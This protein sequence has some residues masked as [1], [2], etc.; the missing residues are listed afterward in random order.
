M[1][2]TK[3]I[4]TSARD[5]STIQAWEDARPAT[6]TDAEV[7]E[8]YNDS[9]FTSATTLLT[10]AGITT[11]STFTLTL[12]CGAGQSFR[13]NANV[14]TNALRYNASNGVGI[15]CTASY[16]NVIVNSTVQWFIMDGLQ[17]KGTTAAVS[18]CD[19]RVNNITIR[20]C[21]FEFFMQ[22]NVNGG[23]CVFGGGEVSNCL[24]I[25]YGVGAG[26]FLKT[27]DG[28]TVACRWTNLTIARISGTPSTSFGQRVPYG[29]ASIMKNCAVFGFN[30]FSSRDAAFGTGLNNASD[31]AIGFGSSNQASVTYSSQFQNI[32]SGTHD[33][34]AKS[35]GALID[36]GVTDTT[37][38]PIDIAGTS[39]PSGSAYD[40]GCWELVASGAS[41]IARKGLAL[42][43]AVNR[44]ST[45]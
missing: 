14:Q 23:A 33:F 5:F 45:F 40:I 6:L 2:I 37:F 35:G 26:S 22:N 41:F 44:A 9:E 28:S 27:F 16:V 17:I 13:D 42:I 32:T 15:R 24:M 38:G 3:T 34:R 12:K 30:S 29:T 4:G 10:V 21:I 43:Q 18:S 11:T 8:C 20:N 1:T 25:D 31:Q 19:V 39:R 7:G 36:N